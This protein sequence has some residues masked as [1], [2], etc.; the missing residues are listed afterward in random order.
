MS[1]ASLTIALILSSF[2]LLGQT[3]KKPNLVFV[4]ADQL[5]NDVLGYNGD[6]IAITP[7]IDK[8]AEEAVNFTNAVSVSPVCAPFRS[9]LLTGK[10]VSSTGMVINEVNMNTNHKTIAHVLNDAGYNCGYVGKMHLN[11]KHTR[12]SPKGPER[13]GFDDYWAS[14]SFNHQSYKSYYFTDDNNGEEKRVDISGKYGPEEFTTLACNYID[15]ASKKDKPFTLFLS[16]NP[17]HDPWVKENVPSHCYDKFK[18]KEFNLPE[19][20]KETPD[21]YMDRYPQKFFQ[22]D[23]I[24]R[25]SFINGEGYQNTMRCYYAMA[26]SIDEQFGRVISHLDS[27]GLSENTIIVFTSDHGEM[28]GSQGRMYKLIFY[29]EAAQIPMLI[30]HPKY[31]KSKKTDICINTP[32]LYPTLLGLMDLSEQIPDEVEGEDLSFVITGEEGDE[33]EFA[34]MQ[35]MGHTYLWN[36][37]YEWRAVRDK[38]YTYAKY[39]IDGSELLFDRAKDPH[40]KENVLNKKKYS[41][42]LK[43][44]RN[45]MEDKME[46]LNDEFRPCSWYRDRWMYKGYSIKAAAKGEFGPLPPVEPIRKMRK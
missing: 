3:Q 37:G 22:G 11:D 4:F 17:P 33:P 34:F 13:F 38:R 40:M 14:Y 32:D 44:L 46:D 45:G 15:T 36:D 19:N 35:G 41:S 5:R 27:L 12:S 21:K 7:N 9:S 2:S 43:K 42:V 16:W 26:N 25:K 28:F 18:N 29:D 39:L 24:W 10:Y 1:L 30:R 31:P 8:F 6:P 20:F 23:S